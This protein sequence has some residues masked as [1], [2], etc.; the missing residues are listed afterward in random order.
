[1]RLVEMIGE[2]DA[3]WGVYGT[4]KRFD[5]EAIGIPLP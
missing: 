5:G 1:V 2:I 3:T 4:W